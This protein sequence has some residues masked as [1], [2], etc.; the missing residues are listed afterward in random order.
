MSTDR[1]ENN[2]VE[3]LRKTL[4]NLEMRI[5]RIESHLGLAT[6]PHHT[7]DAETSNRPNEIKSGESLEFQVGLYWFAKAGITA[8]IIGIIFLLLQP[9]GSINPFFAPILGYF[10][11]ILI[12]VLS[13]GIRRVSPM[14]SSYLKG[15]GLLVFYFSTLRFHYFTNNSAI[16]SSS[17]EI[18]L[19]IGVTALSFVTTIKAGSVYLTGLSLTFGYCSALASNSFQ[20]FIVTVLVLLS[21]SVYLSVNKG[22]HSLPIYSLILTYFSQLNWSLNNPVFGGEIRVNVSNYES[23]IAVL[24]WAIIFSVNSYLRK[25]PNEESGNVVTGAVLNSVI[26]YGTFFTLT[27]ISFPDRLFVSNLL[28]ALTFLTLAVVFWL[29]EKSR[30]QTFF[31]AMT[32]YVALSAAIISQFRMPD[33]FVWLCWQSLLVVSTAVLFR[34]KFIVVAN[35]VIYLMIFLSYLLF[36]GKVNIASISFGIVALLSARVL[37]WQKHRL[38]LKTEKMRNAY[39]VSAFFIIPYALYNAMPEGYIG[40]SWLGVA[41]VYYIVSLVLK[42]MKYRWMA[43]GTFLITAVYLL[44]AGTTRLSGTYRVLSFLLLGIVLLFISYLY[45]RR[46]AGGSAFKNLDSDRNK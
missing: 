27:A 1:P 43:F 16:A 3:Q 31:Y 5:S 7:D 37:N 41:V 26:G 34:S 42:N 40:I 35:F 4:A 30:F 13:W 33:F 12:M 36:G 46:K 44:I 11:G 19:L 39:L 14:I 28:A 25:Q 9:F 45:G 2:E 15:G 21:L 22:W 10:V 29:K 32:G 24:G 23:V 17:I 20:I 18:L 6:V 38:D 8:L